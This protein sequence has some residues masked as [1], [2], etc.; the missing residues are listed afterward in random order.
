MGW[1]VDKEGKGYAIKVFCKPELET[2][3]VAHFDENGPSQISLKERIDEEIRILSELSHDN[4]CALE[5]VIDDPSHDKVYMVMEGLEAGQLMTW[6]DCANAYTIQ[7]DAQYVQ[8]CWG[9]NICAEPI[10]V[11]PT[12][13]TVVYTERLAKYLFEQLLDVIMYLHQLGVIHKDLKPDN[14]MLT[15]PI[16]PAD[17][18]FARTLNI[19]DWPTVSESASPTGAQQNGS[20]DLLELVNKNPVTVKVGDFNSAVTTMTPQCLIYDAQGTNCFT[21][22]ECFMGASAGI[23]GTKRD[24]WSLGCILFVMLFGRCP[25]WAAENIL[26]QLAIMQDDFELPCGVVSAD[27]ENLV[28]LLL[29][30][31]PENRLQVSQAQQ[32]SWL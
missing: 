32:H 27:A 14:I 31:E 29:S 24:V 22:P 17:Q 2:R 19:A 10:D 6:S 9:E 15:M 30:K 11:Q 5:E 23:D 21:P 4:V 28:R 18:R 25:F 13:C 7:S 1:A 8:R 3:H 12:S 20:L 16:P 26:L